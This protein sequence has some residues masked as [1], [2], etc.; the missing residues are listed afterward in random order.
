MNL[1]TKEEFLNA[2]FSNATIE[3]AIK[4]LKKFTLQSIGGGDE[5]NVPLIDS[6]NTLICDLELLKNNNDSVVA[7]ANSQYENRPLKLISEAGCLVVGGI[8]A[9]INRLEIYAKSLDYNNKAKIEELKNNGFTESEIKKIID[10][11]KDEIEEIEEKIQELL[12][13]KKSIDVFLNDTPRYYIGLLK[14]TRLEN[15]SHEN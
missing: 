1:Q 6:V 15:N 11:P 12:I 10:D 13:E 7:I 8:D 9:E 5:S 2:L 3:P 4:E 14:G